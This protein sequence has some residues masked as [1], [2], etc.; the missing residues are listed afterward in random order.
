MQG[1]PADLLSAWVAMGQTER[2]VELVGALGDARGHAA[3]LALA[4][5]QALR[6]GKRDRRRVVTIE[7]PRRVL[8]AWSGRQSLCIQVPL[9]IFTTWSTR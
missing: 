6:H 8:Q 2:A 5:T 9:A 1:V 7:M 4:V 3:E